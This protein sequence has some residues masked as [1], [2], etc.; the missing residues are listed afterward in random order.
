[1]IVRTYGRRN[2][3][4]PRGSSDVVSDG[5]GESLSQEGPQDIYSFAFSSQDSSHWSFDS[6]PYV[7]NSSQEGRELA[8]LAP[9]KHH[10][11]GDSV[12]GDGAFGNLKKK[13]KKVE[14]REKAKSRGG[15]LVSALGT[16]TLMETQEFG[17]MMEHVDEVNFALDGLRKGQQA[18]IRRASLL[19]LLSI[20]GTAQQRRLLRTHGM[21]R[22]IIDAVLGLTFDDSPSNLAAATLFYILTSDGQ[23]DHLLDSPSCI[24]FLIKLLKPLT[25]DVSKNMASTI[26]RK[27]LT[28]RKDIDILQDA[29]RG[30][31]STSAAIMLKVQD[32]L[33]SCKEMK[34]SDGNDNAMKKPKLS[35]KWIAL[36]TMEKACLS[37]IALE[38][39]S[40]TVRNSGGNFKEKL[41]ELGGLNAVFEVARNCHA[42]MERWLE[43]SSFSSQEPKENTDL[44]SLELLLKCLKIMEN[45]TFLSKDNQSHLLEMKGSFDHQG[46]PRFF[47]KLILS[48]IKILSGLSVSRSSSCPSDDYDFC[49]PCSGTDHA[50]EIPLLLAEHKVDSDE[51]ISISSKKC[52]SKE[53][54]SSQKSLSI[55][56]N[57]PWLYNCH[58]GISK[59]TS[60]TTTA[61]EPAFLLKMRPNFSASGSSSGTPVDNNGSRMK[62][63]GGGKRCKVA[64]DT[65]F[66]LLEA[67]QDPFAF[68]DDEF[69]PSK[70]DL[71]HGRQQVSETQN[72][73]ASYRENEERCQSQLTLSQ[74]ES[75]NWE[76]HHSDVSCSSAHDEKKSNLLADCL[77]TAVKVLMNLTNDN[78]VGCQQIAACGGL[79]TLSSLIAGHFPSFSS[80]KPPFSERRENTLSSNSNL[81]VDHENE[82]H[83]SDQELDFLVAILGL[84]VNLVEKDG[85]NRSRL[86]AV[87]VLLPSGHGPEEDRHGDVIPLLCSIFLANQGAGEAAGEGPVL[88]W[89]DETA[90]L[91]GAKEAEKMIV[92]AY[93]ALLLAFLS[94]ESKSIRNSISE[95]L[96]DHNLAILVPVLERFVEFHLTLNMISPET[97][98]TVLEV[99]ES[100]RVP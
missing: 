97:H 27:L 42:I 32:I 51:I 74:Q 19:S 60:E 49:D 73:R 24:R 8:I 5:F 15:K 61:S 58:S 53:W 90:L 57:S 88:S 45:A 23:D 50:S 54:T 48:V 55:S 75:S 28:L 41:R 70:W 62:I 96:P 95:C 35:P 6:E 71:L 46:S 66:E 87:N 92:E 91:Q 72:S 40:G 81:G 52:S 82:A 33:V 21:A 10:V 65:N 31:D 30:L 79:E 25:N 98:T 44:E 76:N 99:I 63:S 12:Y 11:G 78:P 13:K 94:T 18:R 47:T 100:C 56:Q 80:Y 67:S 86:A 26:G 9:K 84:L 89:D 7:S 59:S 36:L 34:S 1:M 68:H 93:A 4:F 83:L 37:T 2:R 85:L 16:A 14:V 43:Q 38:D 77:L 3:S 22:T 64:E 20:C 69:E 29:N 17:E 39:T